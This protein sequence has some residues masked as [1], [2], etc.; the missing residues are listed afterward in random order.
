MAEQIMFTPDAI[1]KL[2]LTKDCATPARFD[3]GT[4]RRRRSPFRPSDQKP[5]P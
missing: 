2:L 5:R 3:P 1:S 4:S